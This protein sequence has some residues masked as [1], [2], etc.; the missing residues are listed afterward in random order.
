MPVVSPGA[1]APWSGLF[2]FAQ[3]QVEAAQQAEHL[4]PD[5]ER[6]SVQRRYLVEPVIV[7]CVDRKYRSLA[8]PRIAVTRDISMQGIGLI[9]EYAPPHDLLAL[10]F[11]LDG[12]EYCV[13]IKV[14]WRK[15]MGPFD[16]L[17]G[18]IVA[19]S[20]GISAAPV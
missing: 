5:E 6:R 10:E 14:A 8:E 19:E 11:T 7:Q 17:G 15:S 2:S 3:R 18:P 12:E 9:M 4:A 1:L 16:F 13:V 20:D